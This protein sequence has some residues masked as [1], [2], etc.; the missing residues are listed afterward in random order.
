MIDFSEKKYIIVSFV[1]AVNMIFW[2]FMIFYMIYMKS[3]NITVNIIRI[4]F[5]SFVISLILFMIPQNIFDT[6]NINNVLREILNF[7]NISLTI[8]F[9]DLNTIRI[10]KNSAE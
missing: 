6:F 5:Q 4:V 1:P 10:I 8:S 3:K 2:V 7:V 9:I